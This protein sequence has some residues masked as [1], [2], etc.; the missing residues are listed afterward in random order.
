MFDRLKYLKYIGT[1]K[2]LALIGGGL[3]VVIA[4]IVVIAVV[5][6]SKFLKILYGELIH[7]LFSFEIMSVKLRF[8]LCST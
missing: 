3:A 4:L 5:T 1:P 2:R 6:K 7:S 8:T